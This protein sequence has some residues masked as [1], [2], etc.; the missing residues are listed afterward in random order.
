MR[1]LADSFADEIGIKSKILSHLFSGNI[2]RVSLILS[3]LSNTGIG[4]DRILK[5][6]KV[7]VPLKIVATELAN[8]NPEMIQPLKDGRNN[9]NE[10]QIR[11]F[12]AA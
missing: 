12:L 11:N 7:F 5:L 10:T 8:I 3:R 2:T 4:R 9:S 1:Q 6:Q